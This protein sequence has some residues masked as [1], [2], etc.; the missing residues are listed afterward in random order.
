M[1]DRD[2]ITGI[3]TLLARRY[4]VPTQKEALPLPFKSAEI[5][6]I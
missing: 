6:Y 3:K 2:P 4:E 5:V 1:S